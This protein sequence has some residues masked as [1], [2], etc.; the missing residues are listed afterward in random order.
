MAVLLPSAVGAAQQPT[1]DADP[2]A[3]TPEEA[4]NEARFPAL[5]VLGSLLFAATV[6]EDE[7]HKKRRLTLPDD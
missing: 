2:E 3:E 6:G 7:S 4:A 1:P 5:A